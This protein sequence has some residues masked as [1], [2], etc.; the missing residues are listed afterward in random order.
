VALEAHLG[1]ATPTGTLGAVLDVS[2]SRWISF[3]C[4]A[5]TDF[6]GLQV[7]CMV[8]PR[9]AFHPNKAI[10]AGVGGAMGPHAQSQLSSLGALA[11]A[12]APLAS[13]SESEPRRAEY[14][15]DRAY[16]VTSEVGYE[17]RLT[18]G[19]TFRGYLG[20][21]WMQNFAD[22]EYVEDD[23]P[24]VAQTEAGAPHA[25]MLYAGA[26]IGYAF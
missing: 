17:G 9:F 26:A 16:W 2:A 12:V 21:R 14:F 24:N 23:R 7:A 13:N 10:Y 8:R 19:M 5:G 6:E 22:Y 4:G 11:I 3:G 18:S 15:W 25:S 20:L 1:V